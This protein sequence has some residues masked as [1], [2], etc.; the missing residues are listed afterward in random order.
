MNSERAG[1]IHQGVRIRL[2]KRVNKER[3]LAPNYQVQSTRSKQN[4][5]SKADNKGS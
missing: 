1:Y 2:P 5:R 3:V 4:T